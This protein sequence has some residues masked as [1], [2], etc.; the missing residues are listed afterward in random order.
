MSAVLFPGGMPQIAIKAP[1]PP[2]QADAPLLPPRAQR[3]GAQPP[4]STNRGLGLAVVVGL[5]AALAWA[6]T[7]GLGKQAIEVVRKPIAM[8]IIPDVAPPPP[9]PPPP[10]PKVERIEPRRVQAPPPVF[11]PKPEV[12]PVEP[13]PAPV[14]QAVQAEPPKEPVI[15]APPAPP[16]PPPPAVVRREIS[17]ACPGYEAVLA[18]SLEE[19]VDRVGIKGTVNALIKIRGNQVAEVTPQSGPKE[20]FKYVQAAVKRM[21]CSAGGADEVQALLPVRFE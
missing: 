2:R 12:V 21:R 3:A 1:P 10:P 8:A 18:Q 19:A 16:S 9:P 7:S 20:Y 14:I 15:I 17:L 13:T 4:A 6:L 11:V 5:H